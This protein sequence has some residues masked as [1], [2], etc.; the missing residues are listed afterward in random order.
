[1]KILII[2]DERP[3][4]QKLIRMLKEIDSGIEIIGILRSVEQAMNRFTENPDPELI[5]MDIQLEDGLC[6]DIFENCKIETPVIFTTAYDE[7][8][9]RAFKVNSVDYLLK[10]IVRE[11]LKNAI[12]KFAAIHQSKTDYS[13]LETVIRQLQPQQKERFL[14]KFGEHYKSVQASTINCFYI[15]ERCTFLF[16]DTAKSYPLDYSLDKIEQL[17]DS[18]LFFRINRDCI[19]NYYAI[20]DMIV[21][22]S[23]RLKIILANRNEDWETVVSRER[24][25]DFKKWMDR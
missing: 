5:F 11:E 20:R 6:F 2:E 23:S 7:Y 10:P 12:D 3:A 14:V 21:Y 16:T 8:A 24:V 18:N 25:A 4:A 9:L 22:S 1:M 13:K 15:K 17:I 19:V